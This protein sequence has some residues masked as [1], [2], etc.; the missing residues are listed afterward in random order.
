MTNLSITAITNFALACEAFFLAGLLARGSR[1]RFSPAWF[2]T[3]MMF[4]L[5]LSALLGGVDHGF[6]EA[7]GLPRYGIQR[8]NWIVIGGVTFFVLLTTAAQFFSRRTQR[9]FVVAGV[10]QLIGY[11]VGVL[12]AGTFTLVIVNY[13]P[14]LLLML[15]MNIA[16][17]KRGSGTWPMIA[18]IVILFAASAVQAVGVNVFD[19]LNASGMYH[20]LLMLAVVFL[21]QGGVRLRVTR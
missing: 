3:G 6:F 18:G 4:L 8:T 19:P 5:G 1:A 9:V 13:V 17:L 21:Y 14:V 16:G 2:W 7:Q 11:S 15:G 20:V 10:V 12:L